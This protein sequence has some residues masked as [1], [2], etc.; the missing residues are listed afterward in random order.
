MTDTLQLAIQWLEDRQMFSSSWDP[1]QYLVMGYSDLARM[2]YLLVRC[3]MSQATATSGGVSM[4]A[5]RK[6]TF[7]SRR[8]PPSHFANWMFV[9]DVDKKYHQVVNFFMVSSLNLIHYYILYIFFYL[10]MCIF[11]INIYQ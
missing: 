10:F 11:I 4:N 7:L 1:Y 2:R 3:N 8:L 9:K 6:D 5:S